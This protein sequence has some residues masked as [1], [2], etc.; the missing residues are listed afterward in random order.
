MNRFGRRIT[1]L[2]AAL[3]SFIYI[4][5]LAF[6]LTVYA[7]GE[8]RTKVVRV[9]W[10][11]SYGFQEVD[12]DGVRSGYCYE[13]LHRVA[14]YTN[15]EYE[16]VNGQWAE[17][18][19]MLKKGEI[20][21]M[22]GVSVTDERRA[23][24]LFPEYAMGTDNYWLFQHDNN[25]K[26]NPQD[27]STLNGKKIGGIK[28]NRMTY[29]LEQWAARNN[30]DLDIF[31]YDGFDARDRDFAADLIDGVV[32]TDNN[33]KVDSGYSPVVKVGSEPFYLAVTNRKPELLYE[34]NYALAD[35]DKADPFFIRKL[36]YNNYGATL[37]NSSLSEDEE[38]WLDE[39]RVWR[40]G[41]F[42]DYM[43]FCAQDSD[44]NPKGIITAIFR[45]ILTNLRIA[46]RVTIEYVPY[47]GVDDMLKGFENHE[48]DVSFPS[49]G[50]VRYREDNNFGYT[51]EIINVPMYVAYK[52]E[53]SDKTFTSIGLYHNPIKKVMKPYKDSEIKRY[54][55]VEA[56]LEAIS[57]GEATCTI[58]SSYHLQSQLN[59]SGFRNIKTMPL[60]VS[61]SY[62]I[63]VPRNQTELFSILN[64][65]IALIDRTVLSDYIF[66][67][68]QSEAKYTLGDFI[69]DNSVPVIVVGSGIFILILAG[70]YMYM[71]G[72]KRAK[73][74]VDVQLK[75]NQELVKEGKKQHRELEWALKK[76][77]KA[78]KAKSEFLSRMSHD[79]RTPLN[80]IIGLMEIAD[81]HQD[82]V[83][84]LQS[85][86]IKARVA[87]NHLL[88][89]INDVLDM[90]KLESDNVELAED[91]FNIED[92][93]AEV[94]DICSIR[95]RE[96]A[97]SI[98]FDAK[99]G[100][101][102]P[103][104]IGSPLHFKQILMNLI[105]NAI[106]Y[107]KPDGTI[108]VS[109]QL[110]YEDD[111]TVA[112][113][114]FIED[115][116]IGISEE[117]LRHIFEPFT[118]EKNDARSR[119]QG[120]GMGMA[121]V[122]ALVDKMQGKIAVDSKVGEGTT[123]A[124]TLPFK[125]NHNV[126]QKKQENGEAGKSVEGMR[127]LVVEDNELN[128]E[129]VRM[130][131][132]DAGAILTEAENGRVAYDI[133]MEKPSGSFDAILMDIM[134]PEW[135]GYE[136]TVQIRKSNKADAQS[137]PI[138]AMTAN[139]FAEDIQKSK[140]AGMNAHIGKPINVEILMSTLERFRSN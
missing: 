119:Y 102:Y 138:I 120:T 110:G 125:I 84:L 32:A 117:F 86:R 45:M 61:L 75:R 1:R 78:S 94:I 59:N 129:I 90:S 134:M 77:E 12:E 68:L 16:Y 118:Q 130:I 87:A 64:R 40:V 7:A 93:L 82:D 111:E 9:G 33:I 81:R 28:N 55:S 30:V 83:E 73:E 114:F 63:C 95:A 25:K 113:D 74:E 136:A 105:N 18:L 36:Q 60:G 13:Y 100:L 21:V 124:V 80:G 34:L 121:I 112:Y 51:S 39:H 17:L 115:T 6:P 140:E 109:A 132:E 24:M 56:C 10:F 127:L 2:L 3:M 38:K 27:L 103:D 8:V 123:F 92:L 35:I 116:G 48:I 23:Y 65:G 46:D 44:G 26:M 42:K 97:I 50:D 29:Y 69:R 58:M 20:D 96:N 5:V 108:K 85:N 14:N 41:Y 4:L 88:S 135:N 91:P 31:Y 137:I 54:D 98:S 104:V 47:D 62:C 53:Y 89:L 107:N 67:C 101:K 71:T 122:K 139:T 128:M 49:F 11:D 131:L 57:R 15:W 52:G 72:L 22:A 76:A 99:D 106:K 66:E 37:I 133:F 126:E 70:L 19:E 43:P 79:I